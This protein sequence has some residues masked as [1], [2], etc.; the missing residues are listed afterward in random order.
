V[1]DL[2]TESWR[3]LTFSG[4]KMH[5]KIHTRRSAPLYLLAALSLAAPVY[6]NAQPAA[7]QAPP[8]GRAGAPVD[9]TGY[10]VSVVTED[11]RYRMVTPAKGDYASVPLNDA[12]RK[13]ADTWDPAKDEAA[14]EQ[15]KAYGAAALMR[16][17]GRLH[18]TWD[19]DN[20]LKIETDAGTQTRMLHFG[21]SQPP[22]GEPQLQ[23]YSVAQWETVGG[24]RGGRG[25]PPLGGSLKVVTTHLRPGY[26]RK[27]GVPYSGNAVLTEYFS[28]TI[29]TNGDSWLIVT[30]IV[31]DPQYLNQPFVTST[32]FKKQADASGWNPSPCTAR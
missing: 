22:A 32:H 10:W 12:G 15:C 9:L 26:L 27:N 4:E 24:G 19:N 18:I 21:A 6:L 3:V 17:P 31:E 25:G 29:E 14:G 2:D 7:P 30:T 13:T 16:V 28:R 8:T 1:P 23:G 20:T 5:Y 11:W